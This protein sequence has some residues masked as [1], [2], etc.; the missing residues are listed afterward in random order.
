MAGV[1]PDCEGGGGARVICL[2]LM[3]HD[4]LSHQ[5]TSFKTHDAYY[6]RS[7]YGRALMNVLLMQTDLK[8]FKFM[9]PSSGLHDIVSLFKFKKQ[10]KV[11]KKKTVKRI[12]CRLGL[13]INLKINYSPNQTNKSLIFKF[14]TV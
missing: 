6:E 3:L 1:G 10:K 4:F 13:K 2:L 12:N 9:L 8:G 11:C 14:K 7:Y 5:S